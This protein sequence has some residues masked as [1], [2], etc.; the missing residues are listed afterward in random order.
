MSALDLLATRLGPEHCIEWGTVYFDHVLRIY[1]VAKAKDEA[2][3]WGRVRVP[4]SIHKAVV[5]R[6]VLVTAW[7]EES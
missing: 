7:A 5:R 2:E 6:E 3:A 1:S 4:K